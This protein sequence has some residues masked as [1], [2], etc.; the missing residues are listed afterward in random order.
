MTTL[1]LQK[2]DLK[3]SRSCADAV[4]L[5]SITI[6][7]FYSS[8]CMHHLFEVGKLLTDVRLSL[9]VKHE[10]LKHAADLMF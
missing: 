9:M 4:Q 6:P 1:S 10:T 3:Q 8:F 2:K 7:S 5:L